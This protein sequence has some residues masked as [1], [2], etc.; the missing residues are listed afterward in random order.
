MQS[1]MLVFLCFFLIYC[2]VLN[3]CMAKC[4]H[5]LYIDQGDTRSPS[6]LAFVLSSNGAHILHLF[7]DHSA[8]ELLDIIIMS[9]T[10]HDKFK[11]Y[12]NYYTS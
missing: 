10:Y 11:F 1:Q 4:Q 2:F 6:V 5:C 12:N 3:V 9:N 7:N 8:D